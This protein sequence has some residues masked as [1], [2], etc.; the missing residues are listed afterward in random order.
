MR[1]SITTKCRFISINRLKDKKLFT[2]LVIVICII[3]FYLRIERIGETEYVDELIYVK[4]ARF[5]ANGHLAS[6][7]SLFDVYA[8]HGALLIVPN[9]V[10]IVAPWFDHPPFFAMLDVPFWVL[11]APRLLPI[12]L[13]VLSTFIVMYLL[14]ENK[15]ESLFAG[16]IFAVYP[17]A[18][19]LNSMMFLDNGS[20]F[21]FL[22][23]LA[24][25]SRF[26][27]NKSQVLLM[28]AGVSAGVS[29]LCKETGVYSIVFLLVY[30]FASRKS[31]SRFKALRAI[32]IAIGI[33]SFWFV[34]GLILNSSLFVDIITA[35]FQRS[36]G[37]PNIYQALLNTSVLDFSI[38]LEE[39]ISRNVSFILL[40]SW[41]CLG[42]F[43]FDPKHKV[44]KL[45][46]LSFILT[47]VVLRYA[48]FFTWIGIY[49][50]FS[51]AIAYVLYRSVHY[52]SSYVH[53]FL[54]TSKIPQL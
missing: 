29:F 1:I 54:E 2:V 6:S 31:I 50:L 23:T 5:L 36:S 3:S 18:V 48:W 38:T 41:I 11:G 15:I 4:L 51:I 32:M 35:Q 26:D 10:D 37:S 12:L 53:R 27:K 44:I 22:V 28:L 21:F 14:R 9:E 49:P 43:V 8:Q 34:I 19:Q 13:G 33:A 39:F 7:S 47:L 24:L 17:F 52:S 46:V 25:T 20:S 40:F 42:I 16:L 30:L 45:G